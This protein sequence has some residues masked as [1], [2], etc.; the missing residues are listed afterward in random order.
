MYRFIARSS[1]LRQSSM[2][3]SQRM[4]S[5]KPVR[6]ARPFSSRMVF[7]AG[8]VPAV[9]AFS[10]LNDNR[11]NNDVDAE[12]LAQ[13][14]SVIVDIVSEDEGKV[15]EEVVDIEVTPEEVTETVVERVSEDAGAEEA[16][17]QESYEGAAYNPETGEINWD[18]PCLG[19]MAHGPCGEEFKEAFA[20]FVYSETEPKGIDCIKKFE[21]MRSCFK[22]YPEHYKE[23]LYEDSEETSE[24]PSK[25]QS[26][27]DSTPVESSEAS[28]EISS[29]K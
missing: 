3:L 10:M 15:I 16:D 13:E 6:I 7:A 25:E 24:L 19:G 14:K 8:L 21:A 9:I 23:E 29:T 22:K 18:C 5:V 4:Y 27:T 12:K 20:C 28:A 11:I 26:E 1:A 17:G 2:R